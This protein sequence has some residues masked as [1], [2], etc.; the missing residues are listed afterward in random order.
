MALQPLDSFTFFSQQ[1]VTE[2]LLNEEVDTSGH[3]E[4]SKAILQA[5][6]AFNESSE[7]Y[8]IVVVL[9][10]KDADDK[11]LSKAINDHNQFSE[12]LNVLG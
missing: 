2:L 7:G 4:F 1:T 3:A 12:V 10:D 11:E 8:K 6:Q 9:S 5:F